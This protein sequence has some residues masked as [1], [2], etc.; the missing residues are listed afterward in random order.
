MSSLFFAYQNASM[1]KAQRWAPATLTASETVQ[2]FSLMNKKFQ[3][4]L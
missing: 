2:Y 1:Q 3:Q 4:N